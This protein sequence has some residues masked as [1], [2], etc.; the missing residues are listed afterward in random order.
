MLRT[1]YFYG[2]AGAALTFLDPVTGTTITQIP[3]VGKKDRVVMR[4]AIAFTDTPAT[5][6]FCNIKIGA[7]GD[8]H[9]IQLFAS[10]DSDNITADLADLDFVDLGDWV[11][12]EGSRISG[13][14]FAGGAAT[15][16]IIFED[17]EDEI[18]IP[19]GR[20]VFLTSLASGNLATALATTNIAQP[21]ATK[22]LSTDST[23]YVSGA[24]T[25]GP[26][27]VQAFILR[28]SN[29]LV[30]CAVGKGRVVF[31]SCPL[32]FKGNEVLAALGQVGA[33]AEASVI[34]ELKEV[35]NDTNM[36]ST[37]TTV[38]DGLSEGGSLR[39]AVSKGASM[40]RSFVGGFK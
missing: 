4:G 27:I 3:I 18:P 32:V 13:T 11:V 21:N 28:A 40:I 20:T 5:R 26:G 9:D 35:P 17:G 7:D 19:K 12:K 22:A 14:A 6:N 33:A 39:S 16:Q 38:E 10:G 36:P 29:G 2:A 1:I 15:G 8:Y 23:Y 24:K 31:P 34:W 37:N 25:L 30:A